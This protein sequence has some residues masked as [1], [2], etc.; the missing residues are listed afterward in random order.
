MNLIDHL[1]RLTKP[2]GSDRRPTGIR[3]LKGV[4]IL[5]LDT[6]YGSFHFGVYPYNW[7]WGH[8]FEEYDAIQEYW[9]LG[10]LFLLV[11]LSL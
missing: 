2:D 9:G 5:S 11:R 8:E 6:D 7:V 1:R 3:I 4:G 10:P